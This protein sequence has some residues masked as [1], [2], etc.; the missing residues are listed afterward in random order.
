MGATATTKVNSGHGGNVSALERINLADWLDSWAP[1]PPPVVARDGQTVYDDDCA[2]CHMVNTYDAN[3]SAPDI[4]GNGAG[5][6][7]KL[8]A[9]H[10]SITLLADEIANIADWL[11]TF[12]AG[13]PYAGACDSCHGQPPAGGSFPDTAGA[14]AVH[15]ALPGVGSNCAVCHD[16][17]SHN[18]WVDLA[19]PS[20]WNAK[21][22]AAADNMD[23]TCSNISC[24]GGVKTPDWN[25]GNIN[26]NTQCASCHVR[27]TS[28]YNAYNSGEHKKHVV[29][30]RYSCDRC[31]DLNKL[32]A[33]HF[34]N[35]S[36]KAFEQSA[37]STI[38]SSLG[39]SGGRC[40]SAGCHG[41]ERW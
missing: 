18:D 27:G 30:K 24:H 10:K 39:Y 1:A 3:G 25:S 38:K 33:N 19:F 26:V 36:T 41:G 17:A 35:L 21:S 28:Q 7:T 29:D 13:D 20:T 12:E 2:G 14:H 23:G 4:A 15:Q 40:S 9:G 34:G 32:K 16:G 5:A 6:V 11:D 37:A 8:N 31:H 22:G